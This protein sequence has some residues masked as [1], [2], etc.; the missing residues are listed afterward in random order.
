MSW[1]TWTP[2]FYRAYRARGR[3]AAVPKAGKPAGA[4]TLV[5][6]IGFKTG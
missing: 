5:Q 6:K 3:R 4:T 2:P 1:Q